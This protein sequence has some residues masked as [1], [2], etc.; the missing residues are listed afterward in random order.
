MTRTYAKVTDEKRQLL[1]DLIQKNMTIK[2]AAKRVD[3]KYENAKAIYRVYRKE[4][5][6]DKRKNRFRYR[7]TV[8]GASK[9]STQAKRGKR[10][11]GAKS[12]MSGGKSTRFKHED[13]DDDEMDEFSSQKGNT[14]EF[15][16]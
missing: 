13:E 11:V 16:N 6:T 15:G 3:V 9:Q 5:R 10:N 2:D 12:R 1:I 7:V 4:E 8:Y 14:S